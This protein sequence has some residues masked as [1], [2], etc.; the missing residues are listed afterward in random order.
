MET[1]RKNE[2]KKHPT[3][4]CCLLMMMMMMLMQCLRVLTNRI[5][6]SWGNPESMNAAALYRINRHAYSV[7]SYDAHPSVD[8]HPITQIS[9]EYCWPM[10]LSLLLLL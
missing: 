3:G 2:R 9:I 1:K 6:C 10:G 5:K 7:L 4:V 8:A